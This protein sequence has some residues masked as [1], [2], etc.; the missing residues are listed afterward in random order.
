MN[1]R[2]LRVD[3]DPN[4]LQAYQRA[5]RKRLNIEPALD[6]RTRTALKDA[7]RERQSVD[8][9]PF[10]CQ[11]HGIWPSVQPLVNDLLEHCRTKGP[12]NSAD[13]SDSD[14]ETAGSVADGSHQSVPVVLREM[15]KATL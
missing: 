5:L 15:N 1:E 13:R 8:R 6:G 4:I 7:Q 2:I 11:P 12:A 14:K 10:A 9:H 3:D